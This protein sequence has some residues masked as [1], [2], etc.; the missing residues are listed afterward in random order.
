MTL[1]E[2]AEYLRVSPTT[3]YRLI[4]KNRIPAF[5]I[6]RHWRFS[7]AA[8]H[9]W[10][11]AKAGASVAPFDNNSGPV[12]GD[13]PH[14]DQNAALSATSLT[15]CNISKPSLPANPDKD[16]RARTVQTTVPPRFD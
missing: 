13:T 11:G 8:I 6:G 16:R 12:S 2:L 10:C 3:I 9:N 4:K 5:K 14:G 1:D 7:T 15:G